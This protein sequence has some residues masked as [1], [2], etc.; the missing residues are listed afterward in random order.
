MSSFPDDR[1]KAR[2]RV[3]SLFYT[4]VR[5]LCI[6]PRVGPDTGGSLDL[7]GGNWLTL[8]DCTD[9][10]VLSSSNASRRTRMP[11]KTESLRRMPTCH[12]FDTWIND[13]R[14]YLEA[15]LIHTAPHNNTHETFFCAW[16]TYR[17]RLRL[18]CSA[19]Y[20]IYFR[21]NITINRIRC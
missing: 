18:R 13:T 5:K 19:I 15:F 8:R 21:I 4:V 6:W 10:Y 12:E 9:N 20:F 17:S 3:S 14:Y 1:K 11:R 2:S 16:A 7:E